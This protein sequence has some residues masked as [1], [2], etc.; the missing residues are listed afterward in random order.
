MT[1]AFL[2]GHPER[3]AAKPKDQIRLTSVV[4]FVNS[5]GLIPQKIGMKKEKKS[6]GHRP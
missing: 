1:V 4:A 3:S 5:P 2:I 6:D